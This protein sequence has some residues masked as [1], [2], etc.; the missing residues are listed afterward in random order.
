MISFIRITVKMA[1]ARLSRQDSSQGD[2]HIV[3]NQPFPVLFC[4]PGHSFERTRSTYVSYAGLYSVGLCHVFD[5]NEI[6]HL[7]F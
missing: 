1:A 7:I 6:C 5:L 2:R 4:H 3:E